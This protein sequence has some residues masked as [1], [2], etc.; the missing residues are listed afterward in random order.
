MILLDVGSFEDFLWDLPFI[1][2]SLL[3]LF[4]WIFSRPVFGGKDG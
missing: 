1:L 3:I 4:Y 2:V